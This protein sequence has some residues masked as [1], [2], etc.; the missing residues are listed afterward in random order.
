MPTRNQEAL[1]LAYFVGTPAHEC[2]EMKR[3]SLIR[4]S[5]NSVA[6]PARGSVTESFEQQVC[7]LCWK[8]C[9]TAGT[10]SMVE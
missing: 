3:G 5:G 8:A 1:G 6:L 9:A 7:T 4:D 2:S 10:I